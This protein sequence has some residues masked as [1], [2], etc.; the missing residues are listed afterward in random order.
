MIGK[1]YERHFRMI[2]ALCQ[3]LL[4][5]SVE[6]EDAAQQTFL[7]A[8]GSMI[9][10]AVPSQPAPWLATIA[11]REC[12]SRSAKRNQRPIALNE[13][14]A[15]VSQSA[16]PLEEAVRHADLNALWR[17]IDN[18]PRQQR[19]AFLMRE[20]SGL[21]YAEVAHALGATES[22]IESLLVR[23]RR[24]LRDGL[25]AAVTT[26]NVLATPIVLFQ[27]RLA[28]LL[29]GQKTAVGAAATTGIPV[30]VKISVVVAG[31]LAVGSAGVGVGVPAFHRHAP[32]GRSLNLL[33]GATPLSTAA[34][35]RSS[36]LMLPLW[37]SFGQ[38]RNDASDTLEASG[39]TTDGTDDAHPDPTPATVGE[40]DYSNPADST[41][42]AA[43]PADAGSPDAA[44]TDPSPIDTI[45]A[46]A[47]AGDVSP[48][49]GAP[50]TTPLLDPLSPD[51]TVR[52]PTPSD[53]PAGHAPSPDSNPDAETT[54]PE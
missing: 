3:L 54:S 17:A 43:S 33:A 28:R 20:F 35:D 11:R 13:A 29:G 27:H 38:P 46:D 19:S 34:N 4:R 41:D 39:S 36:F 48:P 53:E 8:F 40:P 2:R 9:G 24:Q 51:K 5:D 12:W 47:E 25:T 52:A 32:D 45:P 30:A 21:S 22:A 15:P 26:T 1:L 18:L 44:P 6:A 16:N 31:A 42:P 14:N 49:D 10:G 37:D 23:A 50:A 7:S